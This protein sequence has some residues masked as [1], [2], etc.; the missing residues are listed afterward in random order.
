MTAAEI[1]VARR[2]LRSTK[3]YPLFRVMAAMFIE[4]A[5]FLDQDSRQW[6]IACA[7]PEPMDMHIADKV[8]QIDCVDCGIAWTPK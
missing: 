4:L 6:R 7:V 2:S 5:L 1:R 8:P 3:S